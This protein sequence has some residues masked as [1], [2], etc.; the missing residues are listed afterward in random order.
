MNYLSVENLAK[1]YGL[2]KLFNG[3][4][5]GLN[6]GDKV[7]LVATNGKGKSTLLKIISGIETPDNGTVSLNKEIKTAFLP[8]EPLVD[9]SK[10]L[11]QEVFSTDND[12][13]RL[14]QRYI[15]VMA[16]APES[17]EMGDL[18]NRMTE[19]DAWSIEAK[20]QEVLTILKLPDFDTQVSKLSG[21]Q[22]KR[23]GIAK[24]LLEEPDFL[25][26]DEP[27]NHL[28]IDI[29]EW[30]EK[31]LE[32]SRVTLL[33]VT[34]DR[35]FL[36]RVCTHI[37]EL[38]DSGIDKYEGNF[39]LYLE[40]KALRQDQEKREVAKAKNLFK[41]ELEWMRRQPKARGTKAKSRV[42]AFDGIKEKAHSLKTE[43]TLELVTTNSRQGKQ[44]LE[45]ENASIH[46]GD[47]CFLD[48]YSYI[49]QKN[50][51]LGIIGPNGVGKT[52]FLRALVGEQEL[53][54]GKLVKG[55]NTKYGYY[56]Q[57]AA[58]LPANERVIDVVKKVG[59]FLELANGEQISATRLLERFLFDGNM[60][61][62]KVSTLSGGEKKRLQ[63]LIVLISNPN[64]LILDEPT[65][66][67][68][69]QTLQILEE[70]L[71]KFPGCL[72]I[73]SHDRFFL[74][75]VV[76]RYFVFKGE[77]KINEFIGTYSE[78][79]EEKK[80][81]EAEA[82]KQN[83]KA[84]GNTK[85][86]TEE[87]AK[88]SFKEKQEL[89]DINKR[90]EELNTEIASLEKAMANNNGDIV[91]LSKQHGQHKKELDEIELR[92]LELSEMGD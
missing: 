3:V 87:K 34:H 86:R 39:S 60:Q 55:L 31:W 10:T 51:K 17:D 88:L 67:L 80:Y 50:E 59:E 48:N 79:L 68:D 69:V 14:V 15:E 92:W 7:A 65:N 40:N 61:Y 28:D 49:F 8:Q 56:Q 42:S 21:G 23:L 78:F 70:F 46:F 72:L 32:T 75:K 85:V 73:V 91:E 29:I 22:K 38:T 58:E 30:L 6:Q 71:F 62:S 53:S 64:F 26:L 77:G 57:H 76:G 19:R 5:F 66:D 41:S 82:K 89:E 81:E 47:K 44:I 11:I 9:D 45:I 43:A 20:V 54:A 1:S 63:L 52:T 37:I 2:K 36:E 12:D 83:K 84:P 4:T 13:I 74:D 25:I 90:I 33:M 24:V 35:Y 27:T 18:V 16:T